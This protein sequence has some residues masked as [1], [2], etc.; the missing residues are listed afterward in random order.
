[1][2]RQ[3]CSIKPDDVATERSS[4]LLSKLWLEDLHL[5]FKER[6][7]FACLDMRN[8]LM[9]LSEQHVIQ[10]YTSQAGPPKITWKKL[11]ENGSSRQST[12][13]KVAP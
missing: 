6:V 1:M 3:I 7:G 12:L 10:M 4:E 5:V 9:V 8:V 2:I 13:K 11:T